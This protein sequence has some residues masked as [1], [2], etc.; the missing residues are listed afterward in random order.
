MILYSGFDHALLGAAERCGSEP[1]AIYDLQMM[2]N[3]I[4]ARDGMT[5]EEA[6]EYVEY[7]IIGAYLGEDTPW[8]LTIKPQ[9]INDHAD[10]L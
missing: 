10:T 1:V 2:I 7:N 6:R 5:L 3:M 9:E 4:C 8:L